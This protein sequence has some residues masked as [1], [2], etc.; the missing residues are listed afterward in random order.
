MC[1]L[2]RGR[3]V[4]EFH[5]RISLVTSLFRFQRF[6]LVRAGSSCFGHVFFRIGSKRWPKTVR[7]NFRLRIVRANLA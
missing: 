6:A 5:D 2:E 4:N 7:P 1:I 3:R